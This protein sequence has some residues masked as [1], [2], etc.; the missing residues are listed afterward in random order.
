MTVSAGVAGAVAL[1]VAGAAHPGAAAERA[2]WSGK[3]SD[4][5]WPV[6]DTAKSFD[7]EG[8][9]Q[10]VPLTDGDVATALTYVARRFHY[11]IGSLR[12]GDVHGW[13]KDHTV[14]ETYE[15][16]YLSGSAITV[17][18]LCYPVGSK[19]N[20]YPNE[21]VV[22]RDIL[23]ELD[24]VV[25]WGGDFDK[26]HRTL[27]AELNAAGELDWPRACVDGSHIRA[28]KGVPTPSKPRCT[29]SREFP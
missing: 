8:S 4:N 14:M 22:V 19:G 20:L 11:E 21:L 3:Q 27:L 24:G 18:P 1:G 5:G 26:P 17:R 15:S 12:D 9:D 23:A 13:T 10:K 25:A 16:N 28:K 7:I 2:N 6:Q 29:T